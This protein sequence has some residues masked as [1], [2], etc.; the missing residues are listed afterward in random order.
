MIVFQILLYFVSFVAIWLG[1]GLIVGSVNAFSKKLKL[2]SFAV[3]FI[4]L[5][6]LTSTPEFAVGLQ[7]VADH[8][9]EIFVGNLLGGIP[10]I[11]LFV[12]PLLAVFGNGISL[13]HELD[14]KSLLVTL[15]VIIAPC[16]FILDKRVTNPEGVILILLYLLLV[17]IV[18]RKHGIFDRENKHLLDMKAY[19]YKDIA[20][21]LLGI[22]IVFISS[23]IIVDKTMFFANLLHISPFYI[24]LI[25]VSLG[26]NLPELSLAVRSVIT[27]KKD[28]AMGD[29]MGSA[30]ANT[31]LFGM[32]TLLHDGEV[33]TVSNFLTTFLFIATGL[34][35]FYILSRTKN[36][37]SRSDGLVLLVIYVIFVILEFMR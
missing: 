19:S 8:N 5:G 1:S 31:V 6:L 34:G 30:A 18:E 29:Y 26:T 11:F 13:K 25:A 35:I 12:I 14:H 37:I 27:G 32:F 3:S 28:I 33:L 20:K 16:F 36:S 7:A 4:V 10:V 23:N 2:S 21:V 9:P 15:A 24:S 22:G 17:F